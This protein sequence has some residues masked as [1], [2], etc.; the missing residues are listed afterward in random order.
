MGEIEPHRHEP[1]NPDAR[2]QC[3]SRLEEAGM[4][5]LALRVGGLRPH[6]HRCQM[7]EPVRSIWTAYGV[8]RVRVD[9]PAPSSDAIDRMEEVMD[10][11]PMVDDVVCRRIVAARMLTH[12]LSC[13]PIVSYGR[14]AKAFNTSRSTVDRWFWRGVDDIIQKLRFSA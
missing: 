13:R 8:E 12:P 7:P 5:L 4:T 9:W 6:G 14:L 10:W 3:R 11:L 1:R 2:A